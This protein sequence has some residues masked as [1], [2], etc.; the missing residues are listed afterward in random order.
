MHATAYPGQPGNF[1][2][3]G[4]RIMLTNL[5]VIFVVEP[6]KRTAKF[7]SFVL[8]CALVAP[9]DLALKK[10][11]LGADYVQGAVVPIER[12]GLY[13]ISQFQLKLGKD[14]SAFF[15]V[16]WSGLTALVCR[17]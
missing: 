16:G 15:E 13:G 14:S 17:R 2:S 8:P 7:S 12:G 4:G 11:L 9:R 3:Y 1:F 6:S 10:P 5:R